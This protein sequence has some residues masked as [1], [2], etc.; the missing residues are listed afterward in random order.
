MRFIYYPL[1]ILLQLLCTMNI[2]AQS[3]SELEKLQGYA[4][5]DDSVYFLFQNTHYKEVK[6]EKVAV[7][8]NFRS[9]STDM[10]P[11]EWQ[12]T[13]VSKALWVLG[14]VDK[15]HQKIKPRDEF[16]FRI[17]EGEWLNSPQFAPNN[18][19]GNLVFMHTVKA[20]K[21]KAELLANGTIWL[22]VSGTTNSIDKA[23]YRLTNHAGDLI[24]IETILPNTATKSIIIPAQKIDIRRVY[25]L[26]IISKK[27]KVWCSYDGWF[28][29][30][31]STKELG[32]TISD[33][34]SETAFRVFAPRASLL[35][36]Y[37]YKNANDPK[38]YQT[39]DMVQDEH[40]VWEYITKENLKGV[41]YDFTVHGPDELGNHFYEA[42]PVHISDPYARV[43]MDSWGK[44]RV[45]PKTTPA[46]PLK[47]GIPKHEDVIAYEV[48]VQDFTD[49]LPVS[50]DLKGTLPAMY[51]TGLRNKK[52]E[53]IGFDYLVDLGINVIHLMPVQEFLHYNDEEWKASFEDDPYM[54]LNGI[55]TENYQWGYRTSHCF[56]I[57]SRFRQRGTEPGSEREQFRDL[58][59]AFHD[60]GIAVIIDI[61]PNHTAE[62]MDQDNYYFHFNALDKIYYYRTKNLEHIGEYGNE[63]KTENRPMVQ[64]WLIDQCLHFINEFGID[65]FRIDL[66]GQVD[67]QTLKLLKQEIGED[68]ILYGEPWIGSYD[69]EF[70]ENPDWDWYKVDSPIMFFQDDTRNA[71]K[72]PTS[73]PK[74]KL[75]DRG[76]AGGNTQLRERVKKGLTAT[77][78]EETSPLSGI[79][80][81]DIHD[82]WALADQFATKDWDGR[83]G[84]DEDRFKIASV[85]LYTSLGSIVTHGGTEMMRSKGIAVLEE[86]VKKTNKGLNVYLHGKRDTYN[87]RT[88]NQFIW[89]NVGKTQKD[90][91]S[92]CDYQGMYAFW[93]GLNKFRL[94]DYGQVFRQAEAVS[95]DYY[96]WITPKDEGL[97]G[98][99]VD[100]KVLVL[101]NVGD[102]QGNFSFELPKGN[103]KLIGNNQGINHIKG[104][105]DSKAFRT[106]SE[107]KQAINLAPEQFKIWIKE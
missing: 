92:Y 107:G 97:L 41:Y 73:N 22:E 104:V 24:P 39:I 34:G 70:E 105:K 89:E 87:M 30:M 13:P 61:V 17:N 63:V 12:L 16:K 68:K 83:F 82:N 2:N 74:N 23:D 32:A 60:K 45:W 25:Y 75:T 27:R 44:C 65:G 55:S 33:D 67:E 56:A 71:F 85:L 28:R 93:Q 10:T 88:A 101:M 1:A 57:E 79:N 72:G 21:I 48:H 35:K 6:P 64:R 31:Y 102:K 4:L 96:Q 99:L 91:G 69:P 8:G 106:L 58:V 37:L 84:V 78:P 20:V 26:E 42:N 38:A 18:K 77:F 7:T 54:Q 51:Q 11:S 3:F 53:K 80:Y 9:W 86:I 5:R 76:Y 81:L 15:D 90:K 98:Y 40:G 62:N 103:W 50:D 59:Q 47:N 36:L 29:T 19:G 52:G 94:S 43:S 46:T 95:E 49:L 100:E 14:F 66:A